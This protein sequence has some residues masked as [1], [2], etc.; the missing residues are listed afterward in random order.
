MTAVLIEESQQLNHEL[1]KRTIGAENANPIG[2]QTEEA[3]Q[4]NHDLMMKNGENQIAIKKEEDLRLNHVLTIINGATIGNPNALQIEMNGEIAILTEE[5]LRLSQELM[6]RMSGAKFA[7]LIA[8]LKEKSLNR[9][10]KTTVNGMKFENQ[11]VVPIEEDETEDFIIQIIII[12]F[13]LPVSL[14]I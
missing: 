7:N 13:Q 9:E 6:R 5:D 10:L 4:L 14:I 1:M 2:M 8:I 3:L 12:I 11:I